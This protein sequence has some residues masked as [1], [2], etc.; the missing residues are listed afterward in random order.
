MRQ[1]R[2]KTMDDNHSGKKWEVSLGPEALVHVHYSTASPEVISEGFQ[3]LA[4]EL[5]DVADQIEALA[6]TTSDSLSCVR[7][8]RRMSG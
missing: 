8:L 6:R 4:R 7:L 2:N 3:G 1:S 5:R